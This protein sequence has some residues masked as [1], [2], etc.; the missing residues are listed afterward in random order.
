MRRKQLILLAALMVLGLYGCKKKEP[1]ETQPSIESIT[2]TESEQ[3]L[4]SEDIQDATGEALVI[5]ETALYIDENGEVL[6]NE[7]VEA[8]ESSKAEEL[9]NLEVWTDPEIESEAESLDALNESER[10]IEESKAVELNR[11]IQDKINQHVDEYTQNQVLDERRVYL[12]RKVK[13][14]APSNPE[15]ASITDEMIDSYGYDEILQLNVK[16][17]QIERG[18]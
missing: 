9:E 6:S 4:S 8:L 11:E 18:Y 5:Q 7:E 1:I 12:K 17:V 13:E 10:A 16:I 3:E 14:L 2:P 15:L